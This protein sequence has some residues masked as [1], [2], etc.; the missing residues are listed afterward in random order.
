VALIAQGIILLASRAFYAAHRSWNPLIIQVIGALLSLLGAEGALWL[1]G[2][3]PLFKYFI[4]SLFRVSDVPGTNILMIAI[5]ASLGQLVMGLLALLTLRTVAESVAGSFVRP[6]LEG[7]GAAILGGAAS[8]GAL[9]FMGNIAPLTTLFSVFTEAVIAGM[10]GLIASAAVLAL[11]ENEEF[12]DVYRA[13]HS[14][15]ARVL[16]PQSE[17]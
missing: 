5:G 11:L 10:V 8:Y 6:L 1:S 17:F 2:A 16:P 9:A 4:E 13:L 7:F 14:I 12:R 15:R 3:H